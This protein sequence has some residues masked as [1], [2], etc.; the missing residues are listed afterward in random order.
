MPKQ[1]SIQNRVLF[2]RRLALFQRPCRRKAI[3]INNQSA[4]LSKRTSVFIINFIILYIP[5]IVIYD[6]C[7]TYDYFADYIPARLNVGFMVFFACFFTYMLR[8][9]MS[10]N[11]LAMVQ[12]TASLDPNTTAIDPPDVNETQSPLFN[13]CLRFCFAFHHLSMALG[14]IGHHGNRVCCLDRSFGATCW[15]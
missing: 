5:L 12:P 7:S 14:I 2:S 6:M 15:L 13:I 1:L 3:N 9:N 8:A 4:S 10:I 11:L